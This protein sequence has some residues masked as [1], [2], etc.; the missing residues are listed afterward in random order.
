MTLKIGDGKGNVLGPNK[1]L[2]AWPD[3]TFLTPATIA[4]LV[5]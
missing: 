3:N 4:A 5:A 1:A 2:S